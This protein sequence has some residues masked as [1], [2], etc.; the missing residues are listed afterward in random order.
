MEATRL[1]LLPTIRLVNYPLQDY[2][3]V[4]YQSRELAEAALIVLNGFQLDKNHVFRAY[5]FPML[6][7]LKEPDPNWTEPEPKKYVDVVSTLF[8]E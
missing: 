1:V 4:E 2:C 3:F 8:P 5:H 6:D 7:N